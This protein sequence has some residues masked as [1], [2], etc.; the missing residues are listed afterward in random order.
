MVHLWQA[1]PG[2]IRARSLRDSPPQHLQT[3]KSGC[4]TFTVDTVDLAL[5]N[6]GYQKLLA[7]SFKLQEEATGATIWENANTR[8]TLEEVLMEFV[9]FN[10]FYKPGF[11][12]TGKMH[13]SID[14]SPLQNKTVYLTVD[15]NDVE[16]LWSYVT[17]E[18]GDAYFILNT[19]HWNDTLVSLR[20]RYAIRNFTQ[21]DSSEA[22]MGFHDAF[23]WLR[24]FYSES[25]SFLEIHYVKEELPCGQE[26]EVQAEYILDQSK[27]GPGANHVDFYFFVVSRGRIV[28]NGQKQVP[29]GQ[30][31]TLKGSF[32]LTLP[33]SID[34]APSSHLLVYAIFEDGEVTADMETFTVQKCFRNKVSLSFSQEEELP[35]SK[36]GLHL[37][38]TPGSLCSVQAVDKSVLLK[39]DSLLT[40]DVVRRGFPYHLEDFELYPCLPPVTPHPPTLWNRHPLMGAPWY[41]SEADVYSLF[42]QLRMKLFTNTKVKKPISCTRP[43]FTRRIH[44][45]EEHS[46]I[47]AFMPGPQSVASGHKKKE[48]T[49]PRKHFPEIWIWD[50]VPIGEEGETSLEVI[51]PDSITEWRV[52]S[53]CLADVGHETG[54]CESH[55][56]LPGRKC[57]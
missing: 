18:N 47:N 53:F 14:E 7:I 51:I 45:G 16:T 57:T 49:K 36:V 15:V 54:Q 31:E 19:T 11:P 3:D 22:A 1:C 12:Y 25:S 48:K 2:G 46:Y 23:N 44:T 30:D 39:K 21:E 9:D 20:G 38:A 5:A 55:C 50:L 6:P 8:I 43:T 35:G 13:C 40:A 32:S 37:Q 52:S 17:D 41:Q 4:S 34:L 24:P 28:F 42:K 29:V 10:P 56:E 33:I 27:L 26:H